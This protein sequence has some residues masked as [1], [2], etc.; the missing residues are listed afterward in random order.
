MLLL[1]RHDGRIVRQ[2]AGEGRPTFATVG[3]CRAPSATTHETRRGRTERTVPGCRLADRA[4][5]AA[6]GPSE[7]LTAT[8]RPGGTS[9]AF[10]VLALRDHNGCGPAR[11]GLRVTHQSGPGHDFVTVRTAGVGVG[12]SIPDPRAHG[13]FDRIIVASPVARVGDAPGPRIGR[14]D[15]ERIPD[16]PRAG[17][18]PLLVDLHGASFGRGSS[19]LVGHDSARLADR[20]G[21]HL[22]LPADSR[23]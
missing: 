21:R 13:R 11:R 17:R 19:R 4:L 3:E 6:R 15:R 7:R 14:G 5:G 23:R 20:A 10:I 2:V 12:D 18:R 1:V 9:D 8:R 16:G 22:V